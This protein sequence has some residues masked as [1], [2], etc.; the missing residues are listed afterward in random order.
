MKLLTCLT[1]RS[2]PAGLLALA[3]LM[4]PHAAMAD[5]QQAIDS[6]RKKIQ[7][8]L[9]QHAEREVYL[10]DRIARTEEELQSAEKALEKQEE[11][12]SDAISNA[13]QN[14]SD[15]TAR[16][17]THASIRYNRS[18]AR[19]ERLQE[20]LDAAKDELASIEAHRS[21]LNRQLGALKTR[22][23]QLKA[24]AAKPAPKPAAPVSKPA[25]AVAAPAAPVVAAPA[26][27]PAVAATWPSPDDESPANVAFAKRKM[28]AATGK[29]AGQ[30][31]LP[32]VKLNHNRGRGTES[33]E[34]IGDNLYVISMRLEA[35]MW[36][37]KIFN[38]TFWVSIPKAS[39]DQE[40]RLVY[41]V[42]GRAQLNVFR[43]S[44]LN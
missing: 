43:A 36:G 23:E 24:A 12:L 42:N 30:P 11:K 41:D 28:A 20:R 14:P 33:L 19:S 3:C 39:A 44:L 40:F 34:Y 9:T 16:A 29:P 8:T 17:A 15:S 35:G 32:S 13:E 6:E 2:L 25:P 31:P 10:K 22:E 38:E 27:A 1:S 7:S 4:A 26:P 18:E 5:S 37:F 21:E